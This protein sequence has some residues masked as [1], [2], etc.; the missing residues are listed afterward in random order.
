MPILAEIIKAGFCDDIARPRFCFVVRITARRVMAK[1]LPSPCHAPIF[2]IIFIIHN[3]E[4][5]EVKIKL[6]N[7]IKRLNY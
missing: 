3:C 5:F 6:D 4:Q 7:I 2:M 1:S